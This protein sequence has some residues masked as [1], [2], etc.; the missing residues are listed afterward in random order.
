[1]EAALPIQKARIH[2]IDILRGIVM[3][4]MAL[5]HVRDFTS[6]A[7]F[8]PLDLSK[9][10]LILFFTRWITHFCAPTFIF[11]SGASAYLSL[12]KKKNTKEASRFLLTRGLWLIV[13]ELTIIGFGWQFDIGFHNIFTQVIWVI[14]WSMIILSALV[15]LKPVYVGMF[16]LILIFGHNLLDPITSDSFGHYKLVWMFLHEAN[17]YQVNHYESVLMVYPLIPWAGVMAV[18][19]AFGTLFKMEAAARRSLF[20]KIGLSS[21]L[22]FIVLRYFNLYGDPFPWQHQAVWWKNIL[23]FVKCQKY[24]PSLQYVLMTLGVSITALALFDRTDNKLSRIFIV[25][26]RVPLFYYILHVYLIHGIQLAIV[27][28]KGLPLKQSLSIGPGS[29]GADGFNLPVV[30]LI[31][32]AVVFIL[33]FPSRW[34]MKL[35]QWRNDWWLSY[36]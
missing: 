12:S 8:D 11:L 16:G 2:S 4:I 6:N 26:G 15:Y 36:L 33:Y 18:G 3:V 29:L 19:Y 10:S 28:I 14:G 30:Y 34:Y 21:L 24:P 22:L 27:L 20:I 35:K 5:D 13:L 31:W 7:P 9:T 32:L 25:Y 17:F 23:A 1:M